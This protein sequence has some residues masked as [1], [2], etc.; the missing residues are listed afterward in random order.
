MTEAARQST[1]ALAV[2]GAALTA[3]VFWGRTPAMTKF[4]VAEVD[5]SRS[6]SCE[7]CRRTN[8][9]RCRVGHRIVIAED[10]IGLALNGI[11]GLG[12]LHRLPGALYAWSSGDHNLTCGTDYHDHACLDGIVCGDCRTPHAGPRMVD[13]IV[14][15]FP[16][17]CLPGWR[18]FRLWWQR[19]LV[20]GDLCLA[21]RSG[22]AGYIAG[23]ADV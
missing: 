16:R 11:L 9:P 17:S 2:Y 20:D 18:A 12:V 15:G 23:L 19:L 14:D 1:P 3:T 22:P 10:R 6:A 13:R 5:R 7:P 8:L 4:V 21:L